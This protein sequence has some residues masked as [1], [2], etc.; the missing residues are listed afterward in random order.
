MV[1]AVIQSGSDAGLS[2][3]APA[4]KPTRARCAWRCCSTSRRSAGWILKPDYFGFAAAS[5]YLAG[6]GLAGS[7]G[8]YRNLPYVGVQPRRG[9]ER[10]RSRRRPGAGSASEVR[11]EL[12]FDS[13]NHSLL[14]VHHPAVRRVVA[15]GVGQRPVRARGRAQLQ[16]LHVARWTAAT[17]RKSRSTFRPTATRSKAN[18]ASPPR[19]SASP[20]SRNRRRT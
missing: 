3:E 1:D 16:R 15:H 12:K 5:K 18:G 8:W 13:K 9:R 6:Y 17:S 14:D 10:A 20:C 4:G 11:R 7:R 19:S 2:A